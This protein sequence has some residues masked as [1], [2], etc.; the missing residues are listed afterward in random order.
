VNECAWGVQFHAEVT[1][2][3]FEAWLESYSEDADAVALGIDPEK[4]R[5]RTRQAIEKWNRIGYELCTRFLQFA[6]RGEAGVPPSRP[7]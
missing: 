1:L 6:A 3:T 4:M 7:G 5:D 2:Q